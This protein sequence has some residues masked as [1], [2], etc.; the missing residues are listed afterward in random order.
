MP[1]SFSHFAF[2]GLPSSLVSAALG[3]SVGK[4][5][6]SAHVVRSL[7]IAGEP[8]VAAA[9]RISTDTLGDDSGHGI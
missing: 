5:R 8:V 2:G 9:R 4:E 6:P 1:T 7:K 3:P